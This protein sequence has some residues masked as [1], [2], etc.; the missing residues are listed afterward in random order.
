MMPADVGLMRPHEFD[1]N[2]Q[3]NFRDSA[4]AFKKKVTS[5]DNALEEGRTSFSIM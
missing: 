2:H 4:A 3:A 1:N 5:G